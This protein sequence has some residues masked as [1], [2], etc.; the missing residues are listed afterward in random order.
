MM[1]SPRTHEPLLC[2]LDVMV[3]MP[4][5]RRREPQLDDMKRPTLGPRPHTHELLS[6]KHFL[7]YAYLSML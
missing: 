2:G 7:P 4:R 3:V 1:P 5:P 6:T